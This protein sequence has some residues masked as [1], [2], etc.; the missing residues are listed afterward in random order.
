MAP[1]PA[2]DPVVARTEAFLREHYPE[3]VLIPTK[4]NDPT[5]PADK[6]KQPL[7][8]HA[9][10][11]TDVLWK[12]WERRGRAKCA[13]GAVIILRAGLIV[14]D[15]DDV[16]MADV[17][18]AGCPAMATT[19]IQ[20][21]A[22][23]RHYFFRRTPDCDTV[24]LYDKAR[25]LTL[26][27]G[28]PM[29]LDIKTVCATRSG[30]AISVYPSPGKRWLRPPYEHPPIDLPKSLLD[31]IVA[32]HKDM[33]RRGQ[34]PRA[35][36]SA[37]ASAYSAD[38]PYPTANR[39]E[40]RA[41]LMEC[42]DVKRADDY[43]EW[44]RVGM[45][46]RNEHPSLL[47]V[48]EEFSRRCATKFDKNVDACDD[49][50][51]TFGRLPDACRPVM[52]GTIHA[53]A[54]ADNPGRYAAITGRAPEAVLRW[55]LPMLPSSPPPEPVVDIA[56]AP[57]A[58]DDDTISIASASSSQLTATSSCEMTR[59]LKL[60]TT[61]DWLSRPTSDGHIRLTAPKCRE[62]LVKPGVRHD[63]AGT[64]SVLI[65]P[66]L[67]GN[68]RMCLICGCAGVM[69]HPSAQVVN[70]VFAMLQQMGIVERP[71]ETLTEFET[72]RDHMLDVARQHRYMKVAA[73]RR[74]YAPVPGCPCAY[75]PLEDVGEFGQFINHVF[76]DNALF[77]KTVK[78]YDEL[79]A[80]LV[81]INPPH[82]PE[83]K[84]DRGLLSFANG[85]LILDRGE[86]VAHDAPEVQGR[87]ARNHI[88]C[89]YTGSHDTPLVDLILARQ[90]GHQ[91]R[92]IDTLHV[93][94]GRLLFR[95]RQHDNWQ[96]V[97]LLVGE[98]GSGKS[99]LLNVVSALFD[100]ASVGEIDCNNEKAF[101]LQDKY[102][103]ELLTVSDMPQRMSDHLP[104]EQFQ[105]MVSG[106]HV[107]VSVKYGTAFSL[108]WDVP[109]LF[110]GNQ[111]L[112]Y[113]DDAGQTSRRVVPFYFRSGVGG[114]TIT[115]LED[116]IKA[117]ELPNLVAKCLSKYLTAAREHGHRRSFWDWCPDEM[118]EAKDEALA[119]A[120]HL[121]RFLTADPDETSS[122]SKRVVVR[123][124][125]GAV[126][127]WPDLKAAFQAYM[128]YKHPSV[129]CEAL[130]TSNTGVFQRLGYQVR[131]VNVCKACGAE[132]GSC[133]DQYTRANRGKQWRIYDMELVRTVVGGDS[134][135]AL[136][137]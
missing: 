99:T 109:M 5:A 23:G 8:C 76:R 67:R 91:P 82:L 57:A 119:E 120:N 126:T 122:R 46:L 15:F 92:V 9:G 129:K 113:K 11:A 79:M 84:V 7:W 30:G 71:P 104:Q 1:P 116:D 110:A 97:P 19:A 94:L 96:V 121:Y 38:E 81:K 34:V 78:H 2:A 112:D 45:A 114:A 123:Q 50:W 69:T 35:P 130:S 36:A 136:G 127:Q 25:C 95:V 44:L 73:A 131:H 3:C 107:Q 14:L 117:A 58:A 60:S 27:D 134:L 93:L 118:R 17:F 80:Y 20:E 42:V 40:V 24:K 64:D 10:V 105:K 51:M 61:Y 16:D 137:D 90:F 65:K 85:V 12:D 62:C 52:L 48:W 41:L 128:R 28:E 54:K 100:P 115:T 68:K 101:G 55:D 102:A 83:L 22:N 47:G 63:D 31:V 4:S 135:F 37:S 43:N 49:K 32:C 21:T 103:K 106:D 53:W 86:L 18:V 132:G 89:D 74:V 56:D 108:K 133:C 88:P 13:K 87:V 72:L 77:H 111:L 26:A 66:T 124:V 33:G 125:Q 98:A 59:A 6:S 75:V 29:L 39:D 70:A